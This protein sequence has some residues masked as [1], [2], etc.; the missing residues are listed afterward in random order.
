MN[1]M[2]RNNVPTMNPKF[3]VDMIKKVI[4]R[5]GG[6]DPVIPVGSAVVPSTFGNRDG[7]LY[8]ITDASI[9]FS[10]LRYAA[11]MVKVLQKTAKVL[12]QRL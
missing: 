6:G 3:S 12:G 1:S 10:I 5:W 7:T 4:N 2:T 9:V 11:S 8:K